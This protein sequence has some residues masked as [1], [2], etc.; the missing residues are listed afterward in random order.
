MNLSFQ[1]SNLKSVKADAVVFFIEET[2]TTFNK[3]VAELRTMFGKRLDHIIEMENF[4]GKDSDC[5]SILTEGKLATQR[6]LLI[7]L[8][9]EKKL[10]IEK[11]RR[12]AARAA[13][14]AKVLKLGHVAFSLPEEQEQMS[15]IDIAKA[16]AEGAYLSLYK[17]DKYLTEEKGKNKKVS[18]LTFVAEKST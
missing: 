13:K 10:T 14:Q 5:L 15:T 12:A 4:K 1:S 11:F 16:L 7:G 2:K 6:L 8:G 3:R 9:D 17:Y 18:Q